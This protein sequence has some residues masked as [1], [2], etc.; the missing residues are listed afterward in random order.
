MVAASGLRA[1]G[2]F[3]QATQVPRRAPSS[4]RLAL[5]IFESAGLG[6][7]RYPLAQP[8]SCWQS[9]QHRVQPGHRG[10]RSMDPAR[11]AW[12]S[13]RT[14]AIVHVRTRSARSLLPSQNTHTRSA[15]AQ[16]TANRLCV[17]R[18]C[19]DRSL[20]AESA[21]QARCQGGASQPEQG[22][23]CNPAAHR[24]PTLRGHR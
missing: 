23:I 9:K 8:H 11:S 5:P 13:L 17:D 22:P 7:G 18:S 19:I 6:G 20:S 3:T 14:R 1:S 15:L 16:T 10:G 21:V 12:I 24:F 2:R 4:P